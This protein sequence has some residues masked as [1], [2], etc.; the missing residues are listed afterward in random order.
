MNE[1][2]LVTILAF[3]TPFASFLVNLSL[4]LSLLSLSYGL[5]DLQGKA[6][7]GTGGVGGGTAAARERVPVTRDLIKQ[8][9]THL[10]LYSLAEWT[11]ETGCVSLCGCKS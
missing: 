6:Q 5:L 11:Q 9:C 2:G 4:S 3:I 10:P 1:L 7:A 8:V